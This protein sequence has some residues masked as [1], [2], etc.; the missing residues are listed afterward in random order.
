[1]SLIAKCSV[2]YKLKIIGKHYLKAKSFLVEQ[3]Y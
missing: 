1:M 2:K 3:F